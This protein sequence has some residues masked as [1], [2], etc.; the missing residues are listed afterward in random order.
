MGWRRK[1]EETDGQDAWQNVLPCKSCERVHTISI[2]VAI[3]ANASNRG[4][5]SDPRGP[6]IVDTWAAVP[7]TLASVPR[8]ARPNCCAEAR[9]N[10]DASDRGPAE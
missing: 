8:R 7:V 1:G 9:R 5:F 10:G 3:E 4:D 6:A 2:N